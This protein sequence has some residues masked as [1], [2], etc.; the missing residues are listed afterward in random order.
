MSEFADI[1]RAWRQYNQRGSWDGV[2]YGLIYTCNCGW[3]DLGH[4]NPNSARPEIGA[5]NLWRAMRAEGPAVRRNACDP[6]LQDKVMYGVAGSYLRA[7]MARCADD[8]YLRFADGA[9]GFRLRYRQDHAGYTGRPGREGIFLVK[10]GLTETRARAVALSIFMDISH[11][12]EQFQSSIP[13]RWMTDSGYSQEDLVSNLI[14]FYIG[15]GIV[16][17]AQAIAACH[18]VSQA[19]AEN[20]WRQ[21]GAVGANKNRS[22]SPQFQPSVM[23][24]AVALMCRDDCAHQPRRFPAEFQTIT[25]T[26]EGV[27]FLRLSS[28]SMIRF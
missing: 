3:V 5:T 17:K 25:P 1:A 2:N 14:G 4:L 23:D 27:D 22:F 19:T 12:F 26:P 13:L 16:S 7:R 11:R 6:R 20:I 18:P 8:P 21:Q 10:H 28:G 15:L 24:D 9:T